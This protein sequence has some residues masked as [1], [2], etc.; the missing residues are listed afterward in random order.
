MRESRS[1]LLFTKPAV[2]G[3]VKTRLHSMLSPEQAAALHAAFLGDLCE[4]LA[5]GNFELAVAWALEPGEEPPADLLPVALPA[6]RQSG[7]DLGARL[8][9]ALAAAARHSRS[10]AAVGSD[11]PDL[12]LAVVEEAFAA[13]EGGKDLVLGPAADGGY[14]LIGCR[15]AALARRLFDDVPWSGPEVLGT[16][17]ERARELDLAVELLAPASDVDTPEDLERLRRRL[18]AGGLAPCPRTASLLAD[19][20]AAAAP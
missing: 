5:P 17:L 15:M 7:A 18:A 13:L 12:P 3:R 11:H 14:Y 10:V 4:R 19:W 9:N 6:V 16:T 8:Y 1:L 2:P 20:G